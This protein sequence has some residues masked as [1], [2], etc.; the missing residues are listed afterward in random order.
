MVIDDDGFNCQI[1]GEAGGCSLHPTEVYTDESGFM[2]N[3][4]PHYIGKWDS[5]DRKIDDW[6][7]SC[8][9]EGE[10]QCPA[11]A[12]LNVQKMLDGLYASADAGKEVEIK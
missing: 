6:I 10:T 2:I 7:A 11:I 4:E 12:G 1:V 8:R 3:I 9:G 5:M